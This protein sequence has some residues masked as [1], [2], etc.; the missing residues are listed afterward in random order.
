MQ[1]SVTWVTGNA[2]GDANEDRFIGVATSGH[3][4]VVD[5]S[6]LKLANSPLELVLI[7]LCGCTASDVRTILHKKR[8]SF[9]LL[10]VRAIAERGDEPPRV[11]T[12]IKLLYRISSTVTHKAMEDA[13][14]LSEEKY[15]SVAQMLQKTAKITAEI[16][17]VD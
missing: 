17:Y 8:E 16:E 9:S 14:R 13:V 12:A 7:G 4:V 6:Q 15:C 2:A 11:F 3:A 10:E 5:V 1:A